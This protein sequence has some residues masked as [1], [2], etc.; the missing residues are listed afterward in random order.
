MKTKHSIKEINAL[1]RK[2][3]EEL[4]FYW[5]TEEEVT[6]RLESFI[7]KAKEVSPVTMPPTIAF[8][9]TNT[10]SDDD[11]VMM[12]PTV[13]VLAI[14]EYLKYGPVTSKDIILDSRVLH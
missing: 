9:L 6:N 12:L 3:V 10:G 13:D 11:K 7:E 4:K 8:D 1:L 14:L 5:N 2:R